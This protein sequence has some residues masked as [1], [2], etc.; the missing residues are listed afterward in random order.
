MSLTSSFMIKNRYTPRHIIH[1]FALIKNMYGFLK[2]FLTFD[3]KMTK[4]LIS[5]TILLNKLK[6][7]TLKSM[8]FHY[9]VVTC[10]HEWLKQLR[11]TLDLHFNR[12]KFRI[13]D[14]SIIFFKFYFI[15]KNMDLVIK[16]AEILTEYLRLDH[17]LHE[18]IAFYFLQKVAISRC[19]SFYIFRSFIHFSQ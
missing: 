13:I 3:S 12:I 11:M 6:M 2:L 18:F 1:N 8:L 17:T 9:L 4:N 19:R 15:V 5:S 7:C 10:I 14:E 16:F